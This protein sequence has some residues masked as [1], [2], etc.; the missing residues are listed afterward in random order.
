MTY[1]PCSARCRGSSFASS[2]RVPSK[3]LVVPDVGAS[4]HEDVID[5]LLDLAD[6][7]IAVR[8]LIGEAWTVCRWDGRRPRRP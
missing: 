1:S 5:V 3:Q 7:V 6:A 8:R 2:G 4:D